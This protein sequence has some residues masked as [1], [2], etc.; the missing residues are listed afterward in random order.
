V[1]LEGDDA[2]GDELHPDHGSRDAGPPEILDSWAERLQGL[3]RKGLVGTG[4]ELG[5][6]HSGDEEELRFFE[7]VDEEPAAPK[8]FNFLHPLQ[9]DEVA[10]RPGGGN[11]RD[12]A[13]TLV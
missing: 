4:G 5:G 9:V 2:S 11:E 3:L 12:T 6:G 8:V 13:E 10:L 1:V 7:D